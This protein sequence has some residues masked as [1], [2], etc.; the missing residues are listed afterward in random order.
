MNRRLRI[1]LG[2][3]LPLLLT[4]GC[5]GSIEV[6]DADT[7]DGS[8]EENPQPDSGD[9]AGDGGFDGGETS[10]TGSDPDFRRIFFLGR[11]RICAVGTGRNRNLLAIRHGQAL[12][13]ERNGCNAF[14]FSA[15]IRF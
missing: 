5:V 10:D 2:S 6:P 11:L 3:L 7:G 4:L 1:S 14:D 8:Q 9:G 13:L 12:E 15:G